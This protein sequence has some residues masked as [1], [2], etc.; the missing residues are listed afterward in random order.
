MAAINP[1]SPCKHLLPLMVEYNPLPSESG[2]VLV[3]YFINRV[4]P[5]NVL[6][7]LRLRSLHKKAC[8]FYMGLLECSFLGHL[9]L[10]PC[11][12]MMRIVRE[13]S[14]GGAPVDSPLEGRVST[15]S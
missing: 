8:H 13:S 1:F 11:H 3:T 12:H 14:H 15:N 9:L 4:R 6:A 10:K 5:K 7:L 2:L